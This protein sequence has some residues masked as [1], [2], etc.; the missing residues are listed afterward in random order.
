[1][2]HKQ[3]CFPI[4]TAEKYLAVYANIIA[5]YLYED[6]DNSNLIILNNIIYY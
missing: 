1:M 3:I 2:I 6:K 5:C 4:H